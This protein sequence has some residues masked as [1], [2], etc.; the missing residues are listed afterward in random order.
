MNRG[1]LDR[2]ITGN[3][4][5]DQFLS[6]SPSALTWRVDWGNGETIFGFDFAEILIEGI[7][8]GLAELEF[9]EKNG[10]YCD[11]CGEWRFCCEVDVNEIGGEPDEKLLMK[12][13]LCAECQ[14]EVQ[15]RNCHYCGVRSHFEHCPNCHRENPRGKEGQ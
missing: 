5:E 6:E 15:G 12:Y 9:L 8:L 13:I 4:G 10:T 3:F 1:D 14:D 2:Y 11:G 7:E